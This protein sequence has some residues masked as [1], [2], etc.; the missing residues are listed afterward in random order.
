L[1]EKIGQIPD[2]QWKTVKIEK[3]NHKSRTAV[4][5]ESTIT[6]KRY[7]EPELR[8]IFLKGKTIKPAIILANEFKLKTEDAIHRYSRRWLVEN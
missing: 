5:C 3:A 6:N 2:S 7:G 8:H 1:N 4:F